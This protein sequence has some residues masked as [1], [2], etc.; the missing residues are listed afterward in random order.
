MEEES[1]GPAEPRWRPS[2][3]TA[4]ELVTIVV[5]V[6]MALGVDAWYDGLKEVRLELDYLGQLVRDLTETERLM[7]A[8]HPA[9]SLVPLESLLAAF[10]SEELPPSDSTRLWFVSVGGYNNPVPHT[11]VAEALV[12]TGDV[13]LLT[14]ELRTA[15]VRWLSQSRD[16]EL[17]PLYS[18]EEMFGAKFYEVMAHAG[19]PPTRSSLPTESNTVYER[20]PQG[21][22]LDHIY[23]DPNVYALLSDLYALKRRF[24]VYRS[25]QARFAA[26]L[27]EQI[28]EH[29]ATR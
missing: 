22:S 17:I 24:A 1:A 3:R 5:G 26:E 13:R 14:P 19:L 11:S 4:A 29:L 21:Q 25:R 27:R 23:N 16:F 8:D 15:T 20:V 7:T 28:E 10:Q 18:R 2:Y 6:L 12:S 9:N